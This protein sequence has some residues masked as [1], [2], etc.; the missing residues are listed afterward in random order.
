MF[1]YGLAQKKCSCTSW[2]TRHLWILALNM[3]MFMSCI[4]ECMAAA[5][6][7]EFNGSHPSSK[8]TCGDPSSVLPLHRFFNAEIIDHHYST[9]P[10][11]EELTLRGYRYEGVEVRIFEKLQDNTT[12][13]CSFWNEESG[14]HFYTTNP[15][16]C[17]SNFLGYKYQ[18]VEGYVYTQKMEGAVPLYKLW[19]PAK[20]DHFYTSLVSEQAWATQAAGYEDRG[21]A[22]FACDAAGSAV[23][24]DNSF[25]G[26]RN[27]NILISG[28]NFDNNPQSRHYYL[29]FTNSIDEIIVQS[30]NPGQISLWTDTAIEV[31]IPEQIDSSFSIQVVAGSNGETEAKPIEVFTHSHFPFTWSHANPHPI[32]LAQSP[33]GS[34][35]ISAEFASG[36]FSYTPGD[37]IVVENPPVLP[38]AHIFMFKGNPVSFS[39]QGEAVQIDSEGNVWYTQGGDNYYSGELTNAARVVKLNPST[40]EQE[41][42]NIPGN[43]SNLVGLLLDEDTETVW[44]AAGYNGNFIVS[45]KPATFTG[46]SDKSCQYDFIAPPP[47]GFC[48]HHQTADRC[49]QK[50][51]IPTPGIFPAHLAKDAEGN[52]WFTEF[53]GNALGRIEVLRGTITEYSLPQGEHSNWFLGSG[54]WQIVFDGRHLWVTEFFDNHILRFD[55]ILAAKGDC[56]GYTKDE[57]NPCITEYSVPR[58]QADR[59]GLH[60]L[61]LENGG[62]IWFGVMGGPETQDGFIGRLDSVSGFQ[63]LSFKE[64]GCWGGANT[65]TVDPD[66]GNTWFIESWEQRLGL[67]TPFYH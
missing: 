62:D 16:A 67:L 48:D 5:T 36:V 9:G 65:V 54:P 11:F 6:N 55:P 37:D 20:E 35:W 17:N 45:F 22:A 26:L 23:V 24:T 33:D 52:I 64:V 10:D 27:G 39:R 53:F 25:I 40:R 38:E 13:L 34:L 60:S 19:H 50:Y 57:T 4:Q 2:Y 46:S 21:I 29:R 12:A 49:F 1:L 59:T 41:C 31:T 7:L 18:G 30:T 15:T 43:N 28:K 66:N 32:D 3:L 56:T 8:A 58:A 47:V 14:D 42:F 51:D 63:M 61:N 44:A